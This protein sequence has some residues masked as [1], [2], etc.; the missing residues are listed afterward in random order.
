[1]AV[2]LGPAIANWG[3]EE[4]KQLDS[5]DAQGGLEGW[6]CCDVGR[7]CAMGT[8]ESVEVR[9]TAVVEGHSLAGNSF[10]QMAV[11]F[12]DPG[13]T[14]TKRRWEASV[15]RVQIEEGAVGETLG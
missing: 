3:S 1:M 6:G 12:H 2:H 9:Y 4:E 11:D 8:S 5:A 13:P 10:E 7:G 15:G 14:G